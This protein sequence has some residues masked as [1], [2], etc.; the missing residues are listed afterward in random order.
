MVI[1]LYCSKEIDDVL[2]EEII[3][4]IVTSIIKDWKVVAI[5]TNTDQ[6]IKDAFEQLLNL[7]YN[8]L[9]AEDIPYYLGDGTFGCLD[10]TGISALFQFGKEIYSDKTGE[11][12]VTR[13]GDKIYR[14]DTSVSPSVQIETQHI[15]H[16]RDSSMQGF[17]TLMLDTNFDGKKDMLTGLY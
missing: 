2:G 14:T 17:D 5:K 12:G 1:Q 3:D 4:T 16:F 6:L 9:P 7:N 15:L 8:E 10:T 11:W 13:V